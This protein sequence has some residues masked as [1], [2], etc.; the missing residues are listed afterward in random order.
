VKEIA[1]A[2]HN[3]FNVSGGMAALGS[4]IT[5]IARNPNHLDLFVTGTD[6]RIYSTWWDANGG[7]ADWFNVSGGM[8]ALGSP[9]TAVARNPNHL[10]LF[11]TGTDGRI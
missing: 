11:V 7:W 5:A 3:W 10:D 4:P 8:A 2:W 6:R 9:I 1:M